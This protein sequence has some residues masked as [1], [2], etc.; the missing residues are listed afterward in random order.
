MRPDPEIEEIRAARRRISE[1]CGHDLRRLFQRYQ[2]M[3]RK[4]REQARDSATDGLLRET[5]PTREG[6]VPPAPPD[7]PRP[8]KK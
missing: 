3:E 8:K 2:E 1:R 5:P 7:R 4:E 6:A